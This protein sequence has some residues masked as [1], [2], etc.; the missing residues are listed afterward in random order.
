MCECFLSVVLIEMRQGRFLARGLFLSRN[1]CFLS[2]FRES[3]V[4]VMF[5]NCVFELGMCPRRTGCP[6]C[7]DLN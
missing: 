1:V 6:C 2:C 5:L 4:G 3:V 7:K